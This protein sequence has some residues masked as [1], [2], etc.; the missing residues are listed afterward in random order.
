MKNKTTQ[1]TNND[2]EG[3][4]LKDI[5]LWAVQGQNHIVNKLKILIN[6]YHNN[7]AEG[8][9]PKIKNALFAGNKGTGKTVL[10]HAYANSL[11]CSNI[12]ET[13]GAILGMS[14]E[15]V[16]SFLRQGDDSSSYIIHNTEKLPAYCLHNIHTALR[17]NLLVYHAP[18]AYM[19][20]IWAVPRRYRPMLYATVE[21][22]GSLPSVALSSS[23]AWVLY[24]YMLL[25]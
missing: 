2:V 19:A 21:A 13:D 25:P 16:F 15:C 11:C 14:G 10:S 18:T 6:E 23:I 24:L 4:F 8:R 3:E 9:N 1:N 17:S 5:N 7:K 12:Y 22:L 20:G